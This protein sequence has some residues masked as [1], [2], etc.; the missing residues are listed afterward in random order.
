MCFFMQYHLE[1]FRF[2]TSDNWLW[3]T[4]LVS[5]VDFKETALIN[6]SPIRVALL[7]KCTLC[8]SENCNCFTVCLRYVHSDWQGTEQCSKVF[9]K[10]LILCLHGY[11]I[12]YCT[13]TFA[14]TTVVFLFMIKINMGTNI[15]FLNSSCSSKSNISIV[16]I[17]CC[18]LLNT[19]FKFCFL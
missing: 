13:L 18:F 7:I 8:T 15:L 6:Q 14:K 3:F 4:S 12:D 1:P 17:L 2:H 11:I 10:N 9:K 16:Q 5:L 19:G